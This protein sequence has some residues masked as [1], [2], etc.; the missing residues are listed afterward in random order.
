MDSYEVKYFNFKI[1]KRANVRNP[2]TTSPT[3][4]FIISA[5]SV[6]FGYKKLLIQKSVTATKVENYTSQFITRVVVIRA[7]TLKNSQS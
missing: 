1:L 2:L 6:I 4:I 5:P 3:S 7:T